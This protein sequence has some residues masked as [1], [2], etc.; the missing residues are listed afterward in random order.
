MTMY[1]TMKSD[2]V[3]TGFHETQT[4]VEPITEI[5]NRLICIE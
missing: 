3:S 5:V 1:E 4:A 2:F